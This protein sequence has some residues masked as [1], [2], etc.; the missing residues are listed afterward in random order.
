MLKAFWPSA[1]PTV[2]SQ[3]LLPSTFFV[4][5]GRVKES[6]RKSKTPSVPGTG[7]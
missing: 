6:A 3:S 5:L 2:M 7:K 4:P 1:E